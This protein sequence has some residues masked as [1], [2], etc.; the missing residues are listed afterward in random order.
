MKTATL[1]VGETYVFRDRGRGN[2]LI[3]TLVA[4]KVAGSYRAPIRGSFGHHTVSWTDGARFEKV[5][6]LG[7]GRE[8]EGNVGVK[9]ECVT[10]SR[11]VLATRYGHEL[12]AEVERKNDER[13]Q[14]ARDLLEERVAKI[15]EALGVGSDPMAADTVFARHD[16]GGA[17]F[18]K[19]ALAALIKKLGIE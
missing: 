13:R 14:A 16:F 11:Y 9:G 12:L 5:T 10:R 18:S 17:T 1:V 4:V 6:Y 2:K 19:A 3:G 15:N 8:F 7:S